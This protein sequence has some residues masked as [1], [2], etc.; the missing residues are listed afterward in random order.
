MLWREVFSCE[1]SDQDSP[2]DWK[3]C[4]GWYLCKL[5]STWV[6]EDHLCE[7]QLKRKFISAILEKQ[8]LWNCEEIWILCKAASLIHR[9]RFGFGFLW[10]GPSPA[11]SPCSALRP[12]WEVCLGTRTLPH[13]CG[14]RCAR[15]TGDGHGPGPACLLRAEPCVLARGG[16]H[17]KQEVGSLLG[18]KAWWELTRSYILW[19]KFLFLSFRSL[20]QNYSVRLN[21]WLQD[22]WD[23]KAPSVQ[24][25]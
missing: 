12:P 7:Y 3:A 19:T 22:S 1:I 21:W 20:S 13:S 2:P 6:F 9:G 15:G 23:H 18:K 14:A 5:G 24:C 4:H 25:F 11:V 10:Q 16:L 8:S 17:F